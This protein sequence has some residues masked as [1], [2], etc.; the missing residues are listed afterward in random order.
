MG[1]KQKA[2]GDLFENLF[3]SVCNRTPGMAVT[4]FPDGCKVVGRN[5]IVRIKTPCDWI[6]TYGGMTALIDTKTSMN[7]SFPFSKISIHQVTELCKHSQSGAKAGYVVWFRDSD[8]IVFLSSFLLVQAL[9]KRGSFKTENNNGIG[10]V[11]LGK[12]SDFKAVMIFGI[13]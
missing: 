9:N 11:Y 12:S 13:N 5:Q 10:S 4:R 1:T 7:G 3:F 8:E 6:I 2:F